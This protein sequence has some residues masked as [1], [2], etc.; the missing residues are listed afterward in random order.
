[1]GKTIGSQKAS[2]W[3]PLTK[4]QDLGFGGLVLWQALENEVSDDG[5]YP[6]ELHLPKL[7]FL[8]SA[9]L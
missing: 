7:L 9:I 4:R 1:M 2:L 6:E 8:P 3:D 5:K